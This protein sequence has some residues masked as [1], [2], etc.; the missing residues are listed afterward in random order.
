MGIVKAL[1]NDIKEEFCIHGIKC[2]EKIQFLLESYYYITPDHVKVTISSCTHTQMYA[3]Y[4]FR[5]KCI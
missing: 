4:T 3:M 2:Y 1:L 5:M